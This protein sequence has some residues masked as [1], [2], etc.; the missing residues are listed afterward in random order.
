MKKPHY[1]TI[2][3]NAVYA[4]VPE[5]RNARWPSNGQRV[6]VSLTGKTG[7]ISLGVGLLSPETDAV[8]DKVGTLTT[9]KDKIVL[10]LRKYFEIVKVSDV[11]RGVKDRY[12]HGFY[13]TI[14]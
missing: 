9:T 6:S 3:R 11:Y 12:C 4:A 2:L 14:K 10:E 7:V 13:F 8:F 1:P 5:Y